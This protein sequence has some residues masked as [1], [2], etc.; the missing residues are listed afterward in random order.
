MERINLEKFSKNIDDLN[1]TISNIEKLYQ[2]KMPEVQRILADVD[3][4]YAP[5]EAKRKEMERLKI[6]S[7]RQLD[8]INKRVDTINAKL[9]PQVQL[10]TEADITSK[11]SRL[12]LVVKNIA[13]AQK[14]ME[15]TTMPRTS[16]STQ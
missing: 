14:A 5:I 9:N 8:E 6:D 1:V 12:D 4:A 13:A 10:Q 15:D 3:R 16:S 2:Q 7:S 11:L